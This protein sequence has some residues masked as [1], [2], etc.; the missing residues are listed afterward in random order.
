[1]FVL[2]ELCNKQPYIHSKNDVLDL[3]I[4]ILY[5]HHFCIILFT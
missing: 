3:L 1:M 2:I 5:M 4:C